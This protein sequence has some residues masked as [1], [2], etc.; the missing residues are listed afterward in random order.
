MSDVLLSYGLKGDVG[1]SPIQATR[2]RS[3]ERNG[4]K[5][6]PAHVYL[7]VQIPR[8]MAKTYEQHLYKSYKY[9]IGFFVL[10]FRDGYDIIVLFVSLNSCPAV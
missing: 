1:A 4:K 7:H 5:F 10:R 6:P 9:K 2:R 8:Y 3:L